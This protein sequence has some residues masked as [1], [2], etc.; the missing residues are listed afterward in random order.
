LSGL[1][2]G[3]GPGALGNWV[4]KADRAHGVIRQAIL[5][6]QL[7]PDDPINPKRI[8]EELGMSIIP[9]REALRRL[10]QEDLV[11]IRP[12]VGASVRA[13]PVTEVSENFLIRSALEALAAELAAERLTHA[14]LEKL[15]ELM[16]RMDRC[17]ATRRYSDFAKTNRRFHQTI[18]DAVGE[19]SLVR[20]IK[21]QWDRTSGRTSVY[22]V[23]PERAISAQEEHRQIFDALKRGDAAAAGRLMREHMLKARSVHAAAMA[24]RGERSL[25]TAN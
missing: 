17:V 10:E 14:D 2:S 12:H 3:I 20:L 6:G 11:V 7:A 9:I 13:I 1:F 15:E 21:T 19:Q 18:Y 4:T 16:A 5:S 25:E 22:S 24:G 23:V 8:A